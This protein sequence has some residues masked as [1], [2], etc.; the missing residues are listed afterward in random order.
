[1]IIAYIN[2]QTLEYPLF[3]GDLRLQHP[4]LGEDGDPNPELYSPV[5]AAAFPYIDSETQMVDELPPEFVGDLWMQ[6]LSIR[7]ITQQELDNRA[8]VARMR[9]ERLAEMQQAQSQPSN[10]TQEPELNI[11]VTQI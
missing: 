1:M 10:D 6:Q 3:V 9:Q 2:L 5:H 8:E 11:S 7:S 4:E